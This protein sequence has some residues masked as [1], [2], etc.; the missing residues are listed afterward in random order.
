MVGRG[1]MA[2]A[3]DNRGELPDPLDDVVIH[4]LSSGPAAAVR[5]EDPAGVV[6]IH[7]ARC[8]G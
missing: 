4:K 2:V 8:R 7:V 3:G 6:I 1:E 5:R